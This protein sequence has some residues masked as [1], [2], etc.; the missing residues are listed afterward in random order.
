M[1]SRYLILA[2]A[3]MLAA[4]ASA[5]NPVMFL[6]GWNSDG[7]IWG[8]MRSL[9]QSD[10]GCAAGDL[11]AV[12]YYSSAFGYSKSTPIQTVAEGVARE[13][14]EVYYDSGERP[15]DIVA[16]SMGGL[17]VRAMLAYDLIDAKCIGSFV[18]LGTPHYGQNVDDS[19]LGSVV[20]YQ[21]SQMKYGSPFLWEL[22]DAWQ[23]KG[24]AISNTLCVAGS[25]DTKNGSRWD[26]LIHTWSAALADAPCRYVKKCHSPVLSASTKSGAG[27]GGLIG[28]LI[29]GI[30][31][32]L[33]GGAL[34]GVAGNDEASDALY[35][36]SGGANDD[37][38]VLVRDFLKD[39]T[40]RDQ[41]SLSYATLPDAITTKGG[42]FYQIVDETNAPAVF[43]SSDAYLVHTFWNRDRNVRVIAD[44]LEHGEGDTESQKLGVELAFGTLPAGS[45]DLT[46]RASQTTPEFTSDPVEIVG[47]R[48]TVARLRCDGAVL[49]PGMPQV[50]TPHAGQ[51][52]PAT[53]GAPAL[54]SA[55]SGAPD[56]SASATWNGWLVKDGAVQ[57]VIQVKT[58][59]ANLHTGDAAVKATIALAGQKK[60]SFKL[61]ALNM[62]R[63]PS[64]TGDGAVSLTF[65]DTALAGT[66]DGCAIIGA[67]Q[68]A[69][70]ASTPQLAEQAD[71]LARLQ[72]GPIGIAWSGGAVSVTIKARGK[73]AFSG[74][75][76]DGVK[77]SGSSKI[78]VGEHWCAVPIC[79]AKK[80]RSFAALLWLNTS[81]PAAVPVVVGLDGASAGRVVAPPQ[82]LEFSLE[83]AF[84]VIGLDKTLLPY[85]VSFSGGSKWKF[86]AADSIGLDLATLRPFI[87]KSNGNPNALRLSFNAR[88][89]V[90]KGSFRAYAVQ[91]GRLKKLKASVYGVMTG[92]RG[93]GF[94]TIRGA[95]PRPFAID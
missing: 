92:P 4:A 77:V 34:G 1:R 63:S 88:T 16:H 61:P 58:S 39:G 71:R 45:Y 13:I 14:S 66:Y 29:G 67:L 38:Y 12:S 40:V 76:A 25:Y 74:M 81:D 23:F 80:G 53:P 8:T 24:L 42:L 43:S 17:I 82:E 3:A 32:A 89:G 84:D 50:E 35:Q 9:L 46:A 73:V 72:T 78:A 54:Y 37:V 75:L 15:V 20:G 2:T 60:R 31:G 83:D 69:A 51:T 47:G 52:E 90:V 26:G 95:Q 18:T 57:G 30:L 7:N 91:N 56:L 6:H 33:I 70:K 36:C 64:G 22:A 65:G 27:I 44:Y 41:S 68:P 62:A 5:S 86:A 21:T 11:H 87:A 28:E 85:S 19:I 79:W 49:L 10:A 59:K 94:A 93:A 55:V 48:I